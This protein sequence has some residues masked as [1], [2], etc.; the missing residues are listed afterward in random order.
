[1]DIR[2]PRGESWKARAREREGTVPAPAAGITF[3][4]VDWVAADKAQ[5]CCPRL[6]GLG[7]WLLSNPIVKETHGLLASRVGAC[8][9]TPTRTHL[10]R[11]LPPSD[12]ITGV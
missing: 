8:Q 7:H 1:L 6:E 11:V 5:T 3:L 4:G 10:L 9:M 2:Q 12:G